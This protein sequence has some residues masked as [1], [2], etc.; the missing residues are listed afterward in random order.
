MFE[1]FIIRYKN[2]KFVIEEI[3]QGKWKPQLNSGCGRHLVATHILY[4]KEFRRGEELWLANGPFFLTINAP[5]QKHQCPFGLFWR[6]WVWWAAARKLRI[7]ADDSLYKKD[8]PKLWR[9]D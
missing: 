4:K 9:Y 8:L 3:R 2:A 1:D 6:H 7:D 5:H